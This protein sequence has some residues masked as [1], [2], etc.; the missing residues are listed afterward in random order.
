[1]PEQKWM[2]V[3]RSRV[4]PGGY[5]VVKAG[6]TERLARALA[7]DYRTPHEAMSHSDLYALRD[8]ALASQREGGE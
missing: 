1:M 8:A 6:L 7:A 2:V 3:R 4:I 5:R